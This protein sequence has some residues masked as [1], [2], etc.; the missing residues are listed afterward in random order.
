MIKINIAAL[1]FF[2]AINFA[3]AQDKQNTQVN[4]YTIEE[5]VE[6]TQQEPRKIFVDVYTDWCGWCKVMDKNTFSHDLIAEYLNNN[7]Y[8][9]KLNAEQKEDI[10]L[11]D[12]VY[13]FVDKGQRG[14]HELAATLMNGKMSYPTVV[15][16]NEKL[17]IIHI[18]P[19]YNKPKAFDEMARFFGDDHYL[20]KS[21]EQFIADY[22]SPIKQN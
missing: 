3:I 5:A 1:I 18:Q 7:F 21:Y 19:G 4:W 6:L 14:Y 15:F 2:L 20:D 12:K 16:L 10:E 11:G 17:Q 9:V 22:N 13:K 8:P